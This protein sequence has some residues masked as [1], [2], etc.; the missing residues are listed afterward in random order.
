[1]IAL[2]ALVWL[3][4]RIVTGVGIVM[5]ALHNLLDPVRLGTPLWA[6]LHAPGFILRTPEHVVF[7]AYPIV[8]WIGVTAAGYGLGQ[9]Y[10]WTPK[11]RQSFLFGL[12]AAIT[13][14]F[15][16][17]R[18][19][20]VY[21]DPTKFIPQPTWGMTVVSFLDLVKYP[22]S[23]LFLMMTLGPALIF[24]SLVDEG[25]P[26]FLRPAVTYGK[27]PMFYFLVHL[28][29]IHGLAAAVCLVRYGS[30]HWMF[31][32]PDLGHFPYTAPPGWG[33]PLP[34]VYL[35]WIAVVVMLYPACRWFAGVKARRTDAWLSY[36]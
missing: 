8:P 12:G 29:L 6:W 26:R 24:L 9:V 18:L 14:G 3:D 30:A 21:G 31:E 15:V 5:V 2:S 34:V 28:P 32:S 36:L 33:Y 23:L 16:L 22:P 7:A 11:R 10:D 27:V 35:V 1:M 17:L 20:N 4:A 25:T 19:S 13:A